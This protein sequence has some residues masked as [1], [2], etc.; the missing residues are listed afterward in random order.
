MAKKQTQARVPENV[1]QEIARY[2]NRN[3]IER[4]SEAVR[5]LIE[6][7]IAAQQEPTPGERLASTATS[8]A[9]VVAVLSIV[10]A[11]FGVRAA[12]GII[13]PALTTTLVFALLLASI[14]V[15]ANKDLA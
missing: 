11:G 12:F 3:G 4:E 2:R 14:R 10:A 7:G 6:E 9:A 5:Q 15:L 8:I 13:I 1:E